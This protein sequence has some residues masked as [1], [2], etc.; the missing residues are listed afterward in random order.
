[1]EGWNDCAIQ[2]IKVFGNV[3]VILNNTDP[4]EQEKL[5]ELM[6]EDV[7]EIGFDENL[8]VNCNDIFAWGC[9]DAEQ[10]PLDEISNLYKLWLENKMWGAAKWCCFKRNE[11]PQNPV[12]KEMKAANVWDNQIEK[13]PNNYY[14]TK[15]KEI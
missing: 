15:L 1:M 11:K 3:D 4:K 13:L 7:V 14:D 6:R 9:S 12:E 2:L 10:L 5:A 8:Y